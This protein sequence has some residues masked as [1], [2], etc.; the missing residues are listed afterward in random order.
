MK[1][2]PASLNGARHLGNDR[3]RGSGI[4]SSRKM[5]IVGAQRRGGYVR[6]SHGISRINLDHRISSNLLRIRKGSH[7]VRQQ[8]GIKLKDVVAR[9]EA[10]DRL[11][12]DC[13]WVWTFAECDPVRSKNRNAL[14]SLVYPLPGW[15][16]DD[17]GGRCPF[18]GCAP[19]GSGG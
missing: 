3:H 1:N 17:A 12:A 11:V 10:V 16:F 7:T 6:Q 4:H 15:D 18:L 14:E 8:R 2:G 19:H 9:I 13:G 5:E